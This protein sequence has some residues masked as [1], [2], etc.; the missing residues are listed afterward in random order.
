MAFSGHKQ[1]E[2][3]DNS[4]ILEII[5]VHVYLVKVALN[6]LFL[7]LYKVFRTY[8]YGIQVTKEDTFLLNRTKKIYNSRDTG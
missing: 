7:L 4:S 8:I 2:E 6:F 5:N 1:I 3:N